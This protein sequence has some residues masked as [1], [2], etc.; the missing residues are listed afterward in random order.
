VT[1]YL[2]EVETVEEAVSW[3]TARGLVALC[4]RG[5]TGLIRGLAV[6]PEAAARALEA[7]ALRLRAIAEATL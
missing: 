5:E 1:R 6:E 7:R 2:P 3:A 4:Y